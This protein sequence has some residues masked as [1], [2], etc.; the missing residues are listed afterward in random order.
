MTSGDHDASKKVLLSTGMLSGCEIH[1]IEG[2][3]QIPSI[4]SNP[5]HPRHSNTAMSSPNANIDRTVDNFS[6]GEHSRSDL[7][8]AI[9]FL[10]V[11][12]NSV[13]GS[14]EAVY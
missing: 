9:V 2:W 5:L 6:G 7:A 13:L 3:P 10:V 14:D 8:P 12:S 1:K 11:V 4:Q